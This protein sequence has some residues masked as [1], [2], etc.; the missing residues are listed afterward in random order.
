M[1]TKAMVLSK[2]VF[3]DRHLISDVLL[4]DGSK[5]T[6]LFFG[7]Q[8]GGTKS[9]PSTVEIG[10]ALNLSLKENKKSTIYNCNDWTVLWRHLCIEN[11]YKAY[12]LLNFFSEIINNVSFEDM[13]E[14]S[15]IG[16][17]Y[18]IFSNACFYLD[19]SLEADNFEMYRSTFMFFGKLLYSL[20]IFPDIQ[21]C[22]ICKEALEVGTYFNVLEGGFECSKCSDFHHPSEVFINLRKVM[23]VPFK[24]YSEISKLDLEQSRQIYTY[25]IQQFQINPHH[26]KSSQFI[27]GQ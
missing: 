1:H 26:I 18:T 22:I 7:G 27:Y 21:N 2:K 10:F 11:N 6:V 20:G 3:K 4:E 13:N 25:F 8:G 15:E 16:E 23:N 24:R 5:K 14:T 19:K 17:L 9:K 12:F